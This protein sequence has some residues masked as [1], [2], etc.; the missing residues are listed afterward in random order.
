MTDYR[1][2]DYR[3]RFPL[4][5][6]KTY[7]NSCSYGALADTVEQALLAYIRDRRER[8]AC[9]E[10]WVGQ[11]EQLRDRTARLLGA[12]SDEVAITASLSAGFNAFVSGLDFDGERRKVV[13][14]SYDFPTTA[15][16][17][18]AQK[19]R[20]ADIAV[21]RL[22]EAGDPLAVFDALIDDTTQVVS[23]PWV[24]YRN[25]RRLDVKA[26]S[27]LARQRGA[28]VVVDAYQGVGTM[29]CD[30]ND[31]DVDLLL[32]GYLKYLMGTAGVGYMY[33]RKSLIPTLKPAVS[34]WFSQADVH[35]MEIADN[36][37][38]PTARRFEGGTPDVS[39]LYACLAGLELLEEVGVDAVSAQI[40]HLTGAIREGVRQRGWQLASGDCHGAMLALRCHD[41][42]ELVSKLA[43]DNIVVSCRDGNIR[44]SPHFYNDDGDIERLFAA[45]EKHRELLD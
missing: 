26:I 19:R 9:W 7:L 35:A 31:W 13:V 34:G 40:G 39:G 42:A 37:P 30:V 6:H 1:M 33:V 10:Q 16:I 2:S 38:A 3:E 36:V 27:A 22:D 44:I 29:P 43:E 11:L 12:H 24:C 5:A 15:H 18:H 20:G 41:M 17:W 32:G 21:A 45:L 28:L 4:L 25:G 14:T 8:G 23:I